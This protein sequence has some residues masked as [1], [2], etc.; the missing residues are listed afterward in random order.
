VLY[1]ATV[2]VVE[3]SQCPS[4]FG[5]PVRKNCSGLKSSSF[6]VSTI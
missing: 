6:A 1:H 2:Y 5:L 3:F 4:Y